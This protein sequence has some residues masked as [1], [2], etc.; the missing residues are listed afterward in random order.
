MIDTSINVASATE[1]AS[2]AASG[3][4]SHR[5]VLEDA[6]ISSLRDFQAKRMQRS[7]SR[8][9]SRERAGARRIVKQELVD[10][11]ATQ[12]LRDGEGKRRSRSLERQKQKRSARPKPPKVKPRRRKARD[13][14][15]GGSSSA[16]GRE[17]ATTDSQENSVGGEVGS[18]L[19]D[20]AV[21]LLS[22]TS[23][24]VWGGWLWGC[25][26]GRVRSLALK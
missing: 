26:S 2:P 24:V 13:T 22:S 7:R 5:S 12:M 14:T 17:G 4:D 20:R 10:G 19:L 8:S 21:P 11:T 15:A 3:K 23:A 18:E 16:D 9:R 1:A 25:G 6:A